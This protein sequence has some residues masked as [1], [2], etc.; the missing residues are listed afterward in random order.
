MIK[1]SS[2]LKEIVNYEFDQYVNGRNSLEEIY[3]VLESPLRIGKINMDVLDDT[4]K[5][6]EYSLKAKQHG[7]SIG[8]YKEYKIYQFSPI[9]NPGDLH[10]VFIHNDLTYIYFNYIIKNNFV[11]EK[12]IWQNHLNIG[13][14]RNVMFDYYL[15]NFKGIISDT[16]LSLSGEKYWSKLL[17]QSVLNGFKI[18]VLKNEVE[19]TPIEDTENIS[20]YFTSTNYRFVIEN[21]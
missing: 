6:Y 11:W 13:L 8:E 17:K 9:N 4:Q 14:F 12:K 20:Q 7:K 10:D 16:L 5:N 19:K 1:L 18:Y 3:C 21:I 2:M 15:K